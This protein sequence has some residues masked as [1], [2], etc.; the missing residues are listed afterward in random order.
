MINVFTINVRIFST[1]NHMIYVKLSEHNLQNKTPN[2][3]VVGH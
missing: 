3:M 1:D 2:S